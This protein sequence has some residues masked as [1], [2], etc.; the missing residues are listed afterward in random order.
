MLEW[1]PAGVDA[2]VR[3]RGAIATANSASHCS[4]ACMHVIGRDSVCGDLHIVA[5]DRSEFSAARRP[6]TGRWRRLHPRTRIRILSTLCIVCVIFGVGALLYQHD[7]ADLSAAGGGI[8]AAGR[9]VA[10]KPTGN[11]VFAPQQGQQQPRDVIA[12]A[13]MGIAVGGAGPPDDLRSR[14]VFLDDRPMSSSI[15]G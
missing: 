9:I 10:R 13:T 5:D 12:G 11:P 2:S 1:Y 3:D 6:A 8:L 4:N 14:I 15:G 7:A